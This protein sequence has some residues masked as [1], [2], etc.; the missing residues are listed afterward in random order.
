MGGIDLKPG[1]EYHYNDYEAYELT[2]LQLAC[3]GGR[4]EIVEELLKHP[5]IGSDF[6]DAMITLRDIQGRMD[7]EVVAKIGALLCQKGNFHPSKYL[8]EEKNQVLI[9]KIC[10]KLCP[11][12]KS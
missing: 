12:K 1:F 5:N 4:F 9:A 11:P 10:E 8:I 7:L 2:P 3:E 6:F